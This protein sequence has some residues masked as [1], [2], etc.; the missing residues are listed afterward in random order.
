M[1]YDDHTGMPA[2]DEDGLL[3]LT[4]AQRKEFANGIAELSMML[5]YAARADRE[6]R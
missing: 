2:F 6:D 5:L 4:F 1:I 3:P